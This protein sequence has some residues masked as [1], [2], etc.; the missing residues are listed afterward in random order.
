MKMNLTILM[1]FTAFNAPA[2][3]Q[4][5]EIETGRA[6]YTEGEFKKAAVHFQLALQT[7][8]DA[9]ESYH[10]LG[11]AY[12]RLADIALPFGGRYNAKA[13]SCLTMAVD[14]APSHPEYRRELFEFLLDPSAWSR[15]AARQ[16]AYILRTTPE[17]D[18]DYPDMRR[19]FE[20]ESK[21]N[22]AAEARLGRLF[23][24]VPQAAYRVAKQF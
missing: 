24:A 15:S 5:S 16:A 2:A 21:A 1:L 8:P 10:W 14:L 17:S 6:Y 19:R 20:T 23:L 22:T 12:E 4:R 11:L 18:P 7:G 9:A 13:R 3:A